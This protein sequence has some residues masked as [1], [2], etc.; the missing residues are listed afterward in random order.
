MVNTAGSQRGAK[1]T[2]EAAIK[3]LQN[4]NNSQKPFFMWVH[5]FDPHDSVLQPPAQVM[6]KLLAT[7]Y[8]TVPQNK[9][10]ELRAIYDCEISY[11]DTYIGLL[12]A[13]FKDL[14]L[15]N[16]TMIVIVADHGEGLGDHN[17]W[18]HGILY[19][20][21]IRVPLLIHLPSM[22]KGMHIKSLVRTIDIMPTVLEI[23]E[24][25]PEKWPE[26]DGLSL[27][28]VLLAGKTIESREAYSESVNM[29]VY[30]RLD[31]A[32]LYDKKMDKLYS[33]IYNGK[34]L[35]YHQMNPGQSELYDIVEDPRELNNLLKQQRDLSVDF[36]LRLKNKKA[37]SDIMPSLS[38][39]DMERMEKL[40]SLGY[41]K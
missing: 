13:K 39:S 29:A 41:I 37:F 38:P 24:I 18:S 23:M 9:S 36:F 30:V 6:Q 1:E 27:T 28:D 34:K 14:N 12:L 19:Q 7:L 26:M 3:W 40:K 8:K 33:L 17:W 5:Y 35:I 25:Q 32:E 10:E 15:W 11:M 21:Q 31:A 20:E 4:S 2:T 22:K 16:K